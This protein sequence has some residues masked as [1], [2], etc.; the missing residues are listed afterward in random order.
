MAVRSVTRLATSP[1]LYLFLLLLIGVM[2]V[3][4]H[5]P[6]RASGWIQRLRSTQATTLQTFYLNRVQEL[7]ESRE[8]PVKALHEKAMRKLDAMLK[9]QSK[10]LEQA[11]AE[12]KRRYRRN[13]P[14]GFDKWFEYAVKHE[15]AIIDD[16]DMINE[17]IEPFW[18]L[19]PSTI[20]QVMQRAAHG[21]R[22][23]TFS[24]HNGH[25]IASEDN[26]MGQKV[27]EALGAATSSIPNLE[28]LMNPLDEPRVL[29]SKSPPLDIVRW[30]DH[31]LQPSYPAVSEPCSHL[32]PSKRRRAQASNINT[33]GLPFVTSPLS[34]PDFC[35]NPAL[36]TQHGF[37]IAPYSLLTT[38]SPVPILSQAAPSTFS[39]I[40]Y[41]SMWYWDHVIPDFDDYDPRWE[42]K[43]NKVY[44]AGSTTGGYNSNRTAAGNAWGSH[45]HRFVKMT[46][47]IGE[48]VYQFLTRSNLARGNG[49]GEEGEEEEEEE[50]EGEKTG[51]TRYESEEVLAQLYDTKFTRTVQ[52]DEEECERMK[53]YYQVTNPEDGRIPFKSRFLMDLDGNSFSGRFYSFLRSRGC[54]LKQTIFREWHDE[55]LVPWVHYV[56]VSVGMEELP[57]TVRYLALTTEGNAIAREIAEMG[58][59]WYGKVLRKE[60]AAIYLYRLLLEYARVSSAE[61]DETSW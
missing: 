27:G 55:R 29:L 16:F 41:P 39:D 20:K 13:P 11:E 15:S 60:D 4:R 36:A 34:A 26:W 49:T 6:P 51:W 54:P 22:L 59:E 2:Y 37:L 52:C 10:T 31:S 19:S 56:P 17:S 32:P 25:A 9:R 12:Y 43:S 47:Q 18:T 58:R 40:L 38:S 28:L 33:L 23:W 57:E 3:R 46:R 44:W 61:R 5:E 30:T 24:I 50:E 53:G 35:N 21:P 1:A 42:E 8:H 45:R 48:G 14:P 7:A